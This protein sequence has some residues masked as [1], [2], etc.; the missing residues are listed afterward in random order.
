MN[1]THLADPQRH[2]VSNQSRIFREDRLDRWRWW[3][4][5]CWCRGWPIGGERMS[6]DDDERLPERAVESRRLWWASSLHDGYCRMG[7][8]LLMLIALLVSTA[9]RL[10]ASWLMYP[11]FRV[12]VLQIMLLMFET[13]TNFMRQLT[14]WCWHDSIKLLSSSVI[15]PLLSF[16]RESFLWFWLSCATPVNSQSSRSSTSL[17][18]SLPLKL[19]SLLTGFVD[20][21]N[22][23]KGFVVHILKMLI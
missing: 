3:L 20:V 14:N 17:T 4:L 12:F 9:C 23:T 21:E 6:C 13:K 1:V 15:D 16:R 22:E 11:W 5:D 8:M 10:K 18:F 7:R 19:Y 2:V